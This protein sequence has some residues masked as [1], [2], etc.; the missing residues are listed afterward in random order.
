MRATWLR[1]IS[2]ALLFFAASPAMPGQSLTLSSGK[3][4]E[5]LAVG[6]LQSTHGWSSLMLKY[7]TLVSLSDLAALREEVDEIWQRFVV[8]AERGG[9]G[10]AIISANEPETGLVVTTNKS[11]NFVFEKQDG[12]WR[13]LESKERAQAKLDPEFMKEF[14]DR[15]DWAYEHHA[16]NA[17]LLYMA[18]DWTITAVNSDPNGPGPQ[19]MDRAKFV[20]VTNSIFA[21]TTA[22]QHH[23]EITNV[24]ISNGGMAARVESRETETATVNGRELTTSGSTI[25]TFELRGQVMLWT[26]S[27]TLIEKQTE[28]RSD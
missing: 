23:R 21:A 6:P 8:D 10:S 1:T 16:I 17:A 24:T 20:A 19:V 25:D 5:I 9:Y 26:K 12:S 15:L 13:T 28:T 7:R 4:V 14:I 11:Y 27:T 18:N 3:T 22:H 2:L